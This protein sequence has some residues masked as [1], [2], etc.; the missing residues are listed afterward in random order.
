MAITKRRIFPSCSSP[1]C[2]TNHRALCH[3]VVVVPDKTSLQAPSSYSR[4]T[5]VITWVCCSM[6]YHP[7]RETGEAPSHL[8]PVST[9][10]NDHRR[11]VAPIIP[12]PNR[13]LP[14]DHASTSYLPGRSPPP[15]PPLLRPNASDHLHSRHA[16]TDSLH[17][18]ASITTPKQMHHI[19]MLLGLLP[20]LLSPPAPPPLMAMRSPSPVSLMGCQPSLSWA[21]QKWPRVNSVTYPFF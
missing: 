17:R 12:W 16:T 14:E 15:P 21:S 6:S 5:I 13:R 20:H 8:P 7:Q 1:S 2:F 18:W 3:S 11:W 9:V 4:V 19:G 10:V